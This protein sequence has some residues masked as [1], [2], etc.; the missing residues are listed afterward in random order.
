MAPLTRTLLL[1]SLEIDGSFRG[2]A[3]L[4]R[5]LSRLLPEGGSSWRPSSRARKGVGLN[6]SAV[7]LVGRK[8]AKA[9]LRI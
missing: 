6:P 5:L 7:G 1:K 3:T 9:M 4:V 2:V 8:A